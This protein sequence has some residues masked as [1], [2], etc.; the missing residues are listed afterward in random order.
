MCAS[1]L[2]RCWAILRQLRGSIAQATETT[3]Q[4]DKQNRPHML[5]RD[6]GEEEGC[7]FGEEY[8]NVR[9]QSQ[10]RCM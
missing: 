9:R 10:S 6:G 7:V 5:E 8:V 3:F 4:N 1:T 2:V